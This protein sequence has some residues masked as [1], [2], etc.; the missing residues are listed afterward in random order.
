MFVFQNQTPDKTSSK[1]S[2]SLREDTGASKTVMGKD[3][4]AAPDLESGY[5]C[6]LPSLNE[7]SIV[8]IDKAKITGDCGRLIIGKG[9][10]DLISQMIYECFFLDL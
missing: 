10:E 4:A 5:M 6:V 7:E 3:H 9:K 2:I 1:A 8:E